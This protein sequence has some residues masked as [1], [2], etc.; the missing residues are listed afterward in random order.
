[1]PCP[2]RESSRPWPIIAAEVAQE[3]NPDKLLNLLEELNSA[4][5]EQ[6]VVMSEKAE[7]IWPKTRSKAA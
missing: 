6:G 1:M 3:T 4:L 5:E 7:I 2:T